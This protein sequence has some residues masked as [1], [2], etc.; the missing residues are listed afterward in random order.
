M[1]LTS[2]P[3]I[4]YVLPAVTVLTILVP[5]KRKPLVL[6]LGGLSYVMLTGGYPA[7]ILLLCMIVSAWLALR[8]FP[9]HADPQSKRFRLRK[10]T[11]FA[12]C[13]IWLLP[14]K[15]LLTQMQMIPLIICAMQCMEWFS[16]CAARSISVPGLFPFFCG[17][18]EAPR[19]LAGPPM[20][21]QTAEA[22][23]Q[24][25]RFTTENLGEGASL[26]I[27]GLFQL[28]CLALPMQELHRTLSALIP[29]KS[30]FDSW[31]LLA[32]FYFAVYFGLKGAAQIGQGI[33]RMAGLQYP[34]S[35]D[36]PLLAGTQYGF[37]T[38]FLAP[39]AKWSQRM[40]LP[41][42]P[43]E[44]RSVFLRAAITFGSIGLLLGSGICGLLW[45]ILCALL[46]TGEQMLNPKW[47]AQ[48]PMTARRVFTAAVVL[49]V[50]VMLRSGSITEMFDSYL[51]IFGEFGLV[52]H[53]T[54]AYLIK[55]H[56]YTLVLCFAGLFPVRKTLLRYAEQKKWSRITAQVL[57]LCLQ[58]LMLAWSMAELM[59]H[60]LRG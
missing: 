13:G 33:A 18:S 7:L 28:S 15:L 2:L 48:I 47:I 17:M 52:L 16:A 1:N 27:R 30:F 10:Y 35:F 22:M 59:S 46:L 12:A 19:L 49:L 37:W 29:E 57:T 41:E 32:A 50:L 36:S 8:L 26:Y 38:R 5:P 44:T 11:G 54:A 45:G 20:K 58:F 40:I 31:L 42:S 43:A 21:P 9:F 14:A 53:S 4:L 56:W 25:R 39:V 24:Q 51:G 34:D 55:N 23:W 6:A 3:M 60:Y